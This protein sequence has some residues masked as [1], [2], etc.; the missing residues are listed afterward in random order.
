MKR[1]TLLFLTLALLI[2]VALPAAAAG[3]PKGRHPIRRQAQAVRRVQNHRM[4]IEDPARPI[5]RVTPA[6]HRVPPLP[7]PFPTLPDDLPELQEP[8]LPVK[9]PVTPPAIK[10][11]PHQ[12]DWQTLSQR[13]SDLSKR[14]RQFKDDK[15]EVKKFF[16]WP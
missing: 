1:I 11:H 8:Q 4:F 3:G 5:L 13:L 15:A 7:T 9:V 16:R 14:F 6:V 10:Q 2:A 12:P